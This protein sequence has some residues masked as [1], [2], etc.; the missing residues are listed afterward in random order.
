LDRFEKR[1]ALP[2]QA[3]QPIETTASDLSVES[4]QLQ[5][6]TWAKQNSISFH[7]D[8]ALGRDRDNRDSGGD[9]ATCL[10]QGA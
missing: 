9:T 2:T 10:E 3:D 6:E 1:N 8:R 4:Q 5:A 7:I